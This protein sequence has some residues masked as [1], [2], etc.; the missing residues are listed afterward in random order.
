MF[1]KRIVSTAIIVGIFLNSSSLLSAQNLPSSSS[2]G[3]NPQTILQNFS[4]QNSNL[5]TNPSVPSLKLPANFD[6]SGLNANVASI[7]VNVV[8]DVNQAGTYKIPLG[9]RLSTVLQNSKPNRETFRFIRIQ[10]EGKT[11]A[12]DYYRFVYSGSLADNPFLQENDVVN[13]LGFA[14]AVRIVGPVSRPNVYEIGSEKTVADIVKLAGGFTSL[15]NE[16]SLIKIVRVANES[17]PETL[18]ISK[19]EI[20]STK[21]KPNDVIVVESPLSKNTTFDYS[22]ES[23]P[24]EKVFYP[25]SQ[26]I[27]YVSGAVSA[28]GAYPFKQFM[29]V[30]DYVGGAG[31][32]DIGKTRKPKIIRGNKTITAKLDDHLNPGDMIVIHRK[33]FSQFSTG[34]SLASSVLTITLSTILLNDRLKD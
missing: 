5:A 3:Q 17:K 19:I 1:F 30:K 10:R 14:K 25:T 2:F 31:I 12:I 29:T 34:L 26:P 18:S 21:I 32:S 16:D 9:T 15:Y 23:L 11:L 28:P 8:G 33:T 20:Q 13:V 6:L 7:F 22:L 27:V 4:Q 24:G